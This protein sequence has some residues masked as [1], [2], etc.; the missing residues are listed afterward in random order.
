MTKQ[1]EKVI[2]V[3]SIRIENNEAGASSAQWQ[4]P[5]SN[6]KKAIPS[7]VKMTQRSVI[8]IDIGYKCLNLVKVARSQNN[9]EILDYRSIPF[10]DLIEK[11]SGEFDD[12][13]R[14]AVVPFCD[15]AG[16]I[17]I[18]AIISSAQARVQ[19]IRIPKVSEE[20]FEAA[21]QWSLK[22]EISLDETDYSFGYEIHGE[23]TEGGGK[24]NEVMCYFA[25]VEEIEATKKLFAKSGVHLAGVSIVP[26]AI[27]NIFASGKTPPQ[28]ML[29]ACLFIGNDYSRIDLFTGGKLNLTRDIKTGINSLIEMLTED[30]K[31]RAG[32]NLTFGREEARG[33]IF[34]FAQGNSDPIVLPSGARINRKEVE[35]VIVPVMERLTSQVERTFKHFNQAQGYGKIEKL[36]ISSL[37]PVCGEIIDY[38]GER[39]DTEC[40]VFD[41]LKEV[42]GTSSPDER[43]ALIPAFGMALSNNA[44]T[45][46]FIYSYKE[47]KRTAYIAKVNRIILAALVLSMLACAGITAFEWHGAGRG[48]T[49]LAGLE[50]QLQKSPHAS[51]EEI[52]KMAVAARQKAQEYVELSSRY[53]VIALVG[54]L[55]SL[56]PSS[57]SLSSFKADLMEKTS[58]GPP[59]DGKSMNANTATIS[60]VV[61]GNKDTLE[62]VLATYELGLKSSPLFSGVNVRAGKIEHGSQGAFLP[63]ELDLKIGPDK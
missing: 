16:K 46:N 20:H 4:L 49:E 8:G 36:Y 38:F 59:N 47:K 37:I 3:K 13:L 51:K 35:S 24:K 44:G 22:K 10:P 41:P 11:G 62:A 48:K 52:L 57:I 28:E 43:L 1:D 33:I 17:E 15:D 27:Q 14:S 61:S 55:S 58:D 53:R 34:A 32:E 56:T 40:S 30:F 45:P 54:E 29:T 26:F 7:K 23:S 19:F 60:G 6:R 21:V 25:P 9:W 50:R 12:F 42:L 63:F 5:P 31:N 18:W 39:L 2:Q